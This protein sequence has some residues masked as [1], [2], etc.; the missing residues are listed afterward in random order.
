[1]HFSNLTPSDKDL[2]SYLHVTSRIKTNLD[3]T[4]KSCARCIPDVHMQMIRRWGQEQK[5]M[6]HML[7]CPEET[8]WRACW[9]CAMCSWCTHAWTFNHT[10]TIQCICSHVN[11][12]IKFISLS[13]ELTLKAFSFLYFYPTHTNTHTHRPEMNCIS[14]YLSIMDKGRD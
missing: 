14:F 2:I 9:S 7:R 4:C 5:K 11:F 8:R 6:T 1:M 12:P 10:F 3:I 13:N